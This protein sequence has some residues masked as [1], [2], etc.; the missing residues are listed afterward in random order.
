[1]P[2]LSSLGELPYS[3][4]LTPTS[5]N[6]GLP[7][8][9]APH[10]HSPSRSNH[11]KSLNNSSTILL[12]FLDSALR[13]WQASKPPR[14]RYDADYKKGIIP[15]P[16]ASIPNQ[17]SVF[18]NPSELHKARK[19]LH[20][21]DGSFVQGQS[22]PEAAKYA[23]L[24]L[25]SSTCQ[26]KFKKPQ[27]LA[28]NLKKFTPPTTANSCSGMSA[29]LGMMA[30]SILLNTDVAFRYPTPSSPE[31]ID[32]TARIASKAS[33]IKLPVTPPTLKYRPRNDASYPFNPSV[34]A[35]VGYTTD[36]QHTTI[37]LK[38]V[39][40]PLPRSSDA[41]D[42]KVFPVETPSK[43]LKLAESKKRKRD[44][45]NG[46]DASALSKDQRVLSDAALTTFQDLVFDIFG[47]E[48]DARSQTNGNGSSTRKTYF[49]QHE[50]DGGVVL[51][52]NSETNIKL[53][54]CLQKVIS[55]ARF[56]DIPINQLCKLQDLC[57]GALLSADLL[58]VRIE[59][60][61]GSDEVSN[62]VDRAESVDA[63]LRSARTVLRIM[64]GGRDEKQLYSEELLQRILG[65]LYKVVDTCVSPVV[66]SR[67]SGTDSSVFDI[68][69]VQKRV[70][71]HLLHDA[72]KIM[73]LLLELLTKVELAEATIIS[74]EFFV[75]RLLFVENAH[76][77][78]E[79]VL[80]IHKFESIRRAAMNLT[81]Q[82]FLRYSEQR[83][84]ILDEILV[85][86]QKLPIN[87]QQARQYKLEDGTNIQLV[88]AL[89]MRLVHSCATHSVSQS[90]ERGKLPSDEHVSA[91]AVHSEGPEDENSGSE[92]SEQSSDAGNGSRD[93]R[94]VGDRKHGVS[95][96]AYFAKD[97]RLLY[98][99]AGSNAQYIVEFFVSRAS[100]A[101]R[102]GDQPHRHLLDM[103]VGDLVS[104]LNLPEWPASEILLRALFA[105]MERITSSDKS[106][107]PM[108]NM[109]LEVLGTAGSAILDVTANARQLANALENDDSELSTTLVNAFEDHL[110]N[111]LEDGTLLS[112]TGPYRAVLEYLGRSS[113]DLQTIGAQGYYLTQWT[114]LILWGTGSTSTDFQTSPVQQELANKLS[115]AGSKWFPTGDFDPVSGTQCRLAYNLTILNMGF[116]RAFNQIFQILLRAVR[117]DQTTVRSRGLKSVTQMLEKD[118]TLL[119]RMPHVI[120]LITNSASDP[121]P[122]VRDSSLTLIGKCILLQ[123]A[124]EAQ[125][126]ETVLTFTNDVAASIRKHSVKILKDMY[127]RCKSQKIRAEISESLLHRVDDLDEGVSDLARQMVE[128]IW[129][130]PFWNLTPFQHSS[131]ER[132]IA[133]K[134]QVA[135]MIRTVQRGGRTSQVMQPLL[136]QAL[137]SKSK[138]PDANTTACKAMVAAAFQGIIDPT[139]LPDR[140]EQGS[141]LQTLT[142]FSRACPKL[143]TQAQLEHL[144]PY[145]ANLSTADDL[146]IFRSV[147]VIL[148]CV[149]PTL[150]AMQKEFLKQ[151]QEDLLRNITK[152]AKAELDEVVACLWTINSSLGN[153]EKLVNMKINVLNKLHSLRLVDF[154]D[155]KQNAELSKLKRLILLAGHFAKHCDFEP[156]SEKFSS[157]LPWWAGHSVAECVIDSIKPYTANHQPV[158]LRSVAMD[159]IGMICQA[160][161]K[162][163]N[164]PEIT[165]M[166]QHVLKDDDPELQRIVLSSFRDFFTV[167]DH[168]IEVKVSSGERDPLA[169]GKLGGSMTASDNDGAAA[170][171]AQGFLKDI[172]RI[173]LSSQGSY[174]LTATEVVASITRQGLVH[175]KECGPALVALETSTNPKIAEVAFQQ[176]RN[177]HQQHESMF[178]REYMRAVQE[179]YN[180]QRDVV[181]DLKGCTTQPFR[182]KL[183][184]MYEV[185]KTSKSKYQSKFFANFCTKIDFDVTK[186][187]VSANP[188]THLQYARFLIE[189]LAFF[190][191]GR[192]ED[193]LQATSFME[194]IVASTGAGIAHAINTE[195]FHVRLEPGLDS[196]TSATEQASSTV[197][198]S[199]EEIDQARLRQVTTASMILSMLW[200]ARTFL[201]RIYGISASL[202]RRENKS[203]ASKDLGKPPTKI[204]G[205]TGDKFVDSI[206]RTMSALD[207]RD[208]A[209]VQCREFADLLAID[210]EV[211][212]PVEDG[213]D[214]GGRLRTPSVEDDGESLMPPSG[215]SKTTKRKGSVSISGTPH[216]KQRSRPPLGGR[217]KSTKSVDED[218][219]SY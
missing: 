39:V 161:P 44:E 201:R 12:S 174:A 200:E 216:K 100:T 130:V 15:I 173:A 35:N 158:N 202:Q 2:P 156:Q 102:T 58:D 53:D 138:N 217:R 43:D 24:S 73:Q 214:D 65:L 197:E 99:A 63:A 198:V 207:T 107:A 114:K 189:N 34:P 162:N 105:R 137:G 170:L 167:Q 166:F 175:P 122:M 37:E 59:S 56:K 14:L 11:A 77:E 85:S 148:R 33:P 191:Y 46:Y 135:L 186:L 101:S 50:V 87:R 60:G 125:V 42:Y 132:E 219:D 144:Q 159:N 188:P 6:R 209:L 128:D 143:F 38:V 185:V 106:T 147:V 47:A 206:N 54:S 10:Y 82:L 151:V 184:L 127:L 18:S 163:F 31:P 78:K 142:V 196:S 218:E 74:I 29:R 149:M 211:K 64:A 19:I 154:T 171:I 199:I 36:K 112:W 146:N 21:L 192:V 177:L 98:D 16:S 81:A 169:Q 172:L 66:E 195:V 25:Q 89:L 20:Q 213:E 70:I 117:S 210:N 67:S 90:A 110:V 190:D 17:Q 8:R 153:I 140:P 83:R 93:G 23:V 133:L 108:K 119:D 52:V 7:Q 28:N 152:L 129:L 94:V 123:P 160:W 69:S 139:E 115:K 5:E 61:W 145:I 76:V 203:K 120:K 168:Q 109:A 40:P 187:D 96:V 136:V 57:E 45:A 193:V 124:L 150:P 51:T 32:S 3:T 26:F 104:V 181:K 62:W 182:S 126:L 111:Q 113:S 30:N 215:G 134:D 86:L 118:P 72:A 71:L 183:H 178:E 41:S 4:S 84:F 141:I 79:S 95:S 68:A 204:N 55:L 88:S 194:K 91:A 121:S 97:V 9:K 208:L 176:H 27:G 180:Y 205:I 80:G 131:A 103:F 164:R 1:M 22:L 179:A 116:G 13:L 155:V 48:N 212:V 157:K 92:D 165:L 75:I 49:I